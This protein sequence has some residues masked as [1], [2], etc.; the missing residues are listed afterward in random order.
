M[1]LELNSKVAQDLSLELIVLFELLAFVALAVQSNKPS[2]Q[3]TTS[4]IAIWRLVVVDKLAAFPCMNNSLE[5]KLEILLGLG[6]RVFAGEG[7]VDVID[8]TEMIAIF[9][10]NDSQLIMRVAGFRTN[11]CGQ[12]VVSDSWAPIAV[13]VASQFCLS[14]AGKITELNQRVVARLQDLGRQAG[15]NG[16]A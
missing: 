11:L 7:A 1:F 13:F 2:N 4:S 14:V 9:A 16:S 8:G 10:R 15:G 5:F 12:T 6:I 3:G